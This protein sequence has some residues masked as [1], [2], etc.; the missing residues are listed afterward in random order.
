MDYYKMMENIAS[1]Y[2]YELQREQITLDY[3]EHTYPAIIFSTKIS[4][5]VELKM[6]NF[7][8]L[9]GSMLPGGGI[10][11]GYKREECF[12]CC[13]LSSTRNNSFNISF[14]DRAYD[15]VEPKLKEF[16]SNLP[17][18]FENFYGKVCLCLMLNPDALVT[19]DSVNCSSID[20]MVQIFNAVL[21]VANSMLI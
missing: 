6:R 13:E 2:G 16:F 17:I 15:I 14:V 11:P 8:S 18:F 7:T 1:E 19:F 9:F 4:G 10:P 5:D 21:K 3:G 20:N 12:L